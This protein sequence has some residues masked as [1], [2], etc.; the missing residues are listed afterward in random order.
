LVLRVLAEVRV[1]TGVATVVVHH[2]KKPQG[3]N[4]GAGVQGSMH[5][6]RGSGAIAGAADVVLLA[7]A[8]PK[9]GPGEKVLRVVK[10]RD[11]DSNVA[12]GY[13]IVGQRTGGAKEDGAPEIGPVIE[14][15]AAAAV[16]DP[17]KA[18]AD[19]EALMAAVHRQGGK[20]TSRSG[21]VA[22][23]GIAKGRGLTV[24]AEMLA[25]GEIVESRT[26]TRVSFLSSEPAVLCSGSP[27]KGG[28]PR[29]PSHERWFPEP[30]GTVGNHGTDKVSNGGRGAGGGLFE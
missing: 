17:N 8:A 13:R 9:G 3:V 14:M 29:N 22:L 26:G 20:P 16:A 25:D 10:G 15:I 27:L 6:L 23:A 21:L 11:G 2:L 19:K 4:G 5:S 30:S 28:E 1:R 12:C 24:L 7:E 18:G